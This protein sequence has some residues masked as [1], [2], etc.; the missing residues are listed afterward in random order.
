[1][2][3][4]KNLICSF[5]DKERLVLDYPACRRWESITIVEIMQI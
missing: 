4:N 5:T 3:L 1:M 2:G